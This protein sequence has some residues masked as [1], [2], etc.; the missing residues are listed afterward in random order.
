MLDTEIQTWYENQFDMFN[1]DGW[2][3]LTEQLQT[4][5]EGYEKVS[6]VVDDKDLYKKQG[7][8]DILN[9][10]LNW[11]DMVNN[12]YKDLTNEQS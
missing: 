8:L 5:V 4:L 10:I 9:W 1:C 12:Q 6:R 2:K 11:P 3:A 7:Q